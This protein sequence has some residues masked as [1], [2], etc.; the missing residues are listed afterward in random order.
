MAVGDTVRVGYGTI[1]TA[2]VN[3]PVYNVSTDQAGNIIFD[4]LG[5]AT[6]R[7]VGGV[8]GGSTGTIVGNPVKVSKAQLKGYSE[9]A[10][11]MGME[12]VLLYPVEFT[13]YKQVAWVSQDH[14]HIVTGQLT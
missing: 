8:K 7:V 10:A 2:D 13:F 9:G 11:A 6:P 1:D 12:L 5:G 3:V 14:M 4:S